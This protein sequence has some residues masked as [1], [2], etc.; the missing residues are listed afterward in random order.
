MLWRMRGVRGHIGVPSYLV[1][2][3]VTGVSKVKARVFF[4]V[5]IASCYCRLSWPA[6]ASVTSAEGRKQRQAP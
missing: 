1:N 5:C 6:A 4:L 2:E 3:S